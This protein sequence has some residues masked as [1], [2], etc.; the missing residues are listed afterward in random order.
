MVWHE[1]AE[2]RVGGRWIAVD[3]SFGQAPARGARF[4]LARWTHGDAA[5]RAAAGKKILRCWSRE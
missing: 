5:S 1:W 2:L 3:P 4:T